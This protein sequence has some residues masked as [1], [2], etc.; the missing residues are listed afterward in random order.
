MRVAALMVLFVVSLMDLSE[1][2]RWRPSAMHLWRFDNETIIEEPK[3]NQTES[4]AEHV[5]VVEGNATQPIGDGGALEGTLE[6]CRNGVNRPSSTNCSTFLVCN[7]G[8]ETEGFCPPD[9]WYDPNHK[10]DML[11]NHPE[12]VC[13]ADQSVCDCASQYPV[14]A[15]DPLIEQ[16]VTCM[17]DNRFHFTSS[18]VDCGRYFVCFNGNVRRMECKAG[19]QFDPKT[20]LCDYPEM[21]NCKVFTHV[22]VVF[23][24]R[25]TYI[26]I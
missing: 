21:V 4:V 16:D 11:C 1:A 24:S 5:N 25:Y 7:E 23:R 14:L 2:K 13:A 19:F 3:P 18:R 26:H 6:Q 10:G 12:I 17:A 22:K 9:F 20:E 8:V 15:P